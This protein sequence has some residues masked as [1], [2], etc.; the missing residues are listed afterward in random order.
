MD[1]Y[2][3]DLQSPASLHKYVHGWNDPVNHVDRSG[4]GIEDTLTAA[5]VAVTNFAA[6]VPYLL[7]I[8]GY[9]FAALNIGLFIANDDYRVVVA[10]NPDLS[11]ALYE[12]VA[13]VFE[14]GESAVAG[15]F[16]VARGASTRKA[17]LDLG[18]G[19]ISQIAGATNIDRIAIQGIRGDYTD[20]AEF[21]EPGTYDIVVS[22]GPRDDVF[23]AA[24]YALKSGCRLYINATQ[25]NKF[26]R[27]PD[28]STLDGLR[29][30]LLQEAGPLDSQFSGLTFRATNGDQIP[31]S[32]VRTTVLEKF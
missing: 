24:S 5:Y 1:T 22:S 3:G 14:G 11:H 29:L 32:Q 28:Q 12:D 2:E 23:P 31:T 15:I 19:A 27:I 26:A 25:S 7:P 18:G 21:F 9:S 30:R 20:V 16:T 13:L 17:I 8:I 10:A 4:H 6:S